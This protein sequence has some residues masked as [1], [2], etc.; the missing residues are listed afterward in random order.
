MDVGGKSISTPV[1]IMFYSE[2]EVLNVN[3][4]IKKFELVVHPKSETTVH[5]D[6]NSFDSE[7]HKL[8]NH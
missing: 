7:N 8:E 3:Q 5:H 6:I 2:F 1:A 4:I